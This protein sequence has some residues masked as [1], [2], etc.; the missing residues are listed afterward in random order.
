M[1]RRFVQYHTTADTAVHTLLFYPFLGR[2]ED[3]TF[4]HVSN[5]SST[6]YTAPLSGRQCA[7]LHVGWLVDFCEAVM[8]KKERAE[9]KRHALKRQKALFLFLSS[10]FL[11]LMT[12]IC[13]N[14]Y[15]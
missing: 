2:G 10:G 3:V 1:R 4:L 11:A 12:T 13:K 9:W 6:G 14:I 5:W 8:R 7:P 15:I